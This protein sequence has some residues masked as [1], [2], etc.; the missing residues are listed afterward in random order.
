MGQREAEL[1]QWRAARAKPLASRASL[2]NIPSAQGRPEPKRGV[3]VRKAGAA[4][5]LLAG[6]PAV[7]RVVRLLRTA[8]DPAH[9]HCPQS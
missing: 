6:E 2:H 8:R 3:P 5:V 9:G 4:Q 1:Q 7:W